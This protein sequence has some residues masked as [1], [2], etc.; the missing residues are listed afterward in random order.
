ML[1]CKNT[2]YEIND[3]FSETRKMVEIGSGDNLS[4]TGTTT[5][6][7]MAQVLYNLLSR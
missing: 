1:A 5:R 3:N 6:A 4:P 7:E 2:G